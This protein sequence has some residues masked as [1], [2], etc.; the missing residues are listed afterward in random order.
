[1]KIGKKIQTFPD[2]RNTDKPLSF[3]TSSQFGDVLQNSH[4]QFSSERL[5]QLLGEIDKQGTRLSNAQTVKDLQLYKKLIKDFV[6]EAISFGMQLSENKNWNQ[7]GQA[8]THILVKQVDEQLMNLTD[9][10]LNKEK[11]QIEVLNKIGEIHGLLINL[12]T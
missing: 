3:K 10:I 1:M 9:Q 7:Q 2:T 8:R 4:K 6:K 12:Y 11:K 5:N